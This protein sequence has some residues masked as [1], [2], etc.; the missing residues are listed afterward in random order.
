MILSNTGKAAI[1]AVIYL[2]S[3]YEREAKA[4]IREIAIEVG[5]NEHTVAKLLQTLVK[6]NVIMSLKGPS[7]GF[8]LSKKQYGQPLLNVA[9]AID[10]KN[11][12]NTCGLGLKKCFKNHPCPIHFEYQVA[13]DFLEKLYATKKISDLSTVFSDGK[14]FLCD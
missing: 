4:N 10:G 6:Q 1:K 13:R 12:F 2:A 3:K 14:A 9:E 7:G 8:Y 11:L 5:E